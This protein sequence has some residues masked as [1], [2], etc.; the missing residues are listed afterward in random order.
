[1]Q[2]VVTTELSLPTNVALVQILASTLIPLLVTKK[3]LKNK[4]NEVS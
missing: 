1:M 2:L 4:I 3:N